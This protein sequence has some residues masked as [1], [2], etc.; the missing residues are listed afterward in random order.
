[1]NIAETIVYCG[2]SDIEFY[3]QSSEWRYCVKKDEDNALP[4]DI[5]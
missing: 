5:H 2:F 4:I 1:M 3:F